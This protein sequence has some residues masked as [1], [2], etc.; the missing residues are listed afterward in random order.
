M[1]EKN[2]LRREAKIKRD[3]LNP[4]EKKLLDSAIC[5]KVLALAAK[6]K[7]KPV[8][9]Y[10]AKGSETDLSEAIVKMLSDGFTVAVPRVYGKKEMKFQ[11]IVSFDDLEDGVFGL[12]EP[13]KSCPVVLP[14]GSIVFVPG[15]AFG[16]DGER[17]GYGAGYY[18]R[19]FSEHKGNL[20]IG[21]CYDFQILEKIGT[22]PSDVPMYSVLTEKRDAEI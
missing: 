21:T 7:D 10:I 6:F 5:G 9:V 15:L 2:I 20:L 14:F 13:K 1:P 8:L 22:E 19:Y 4:S 12:K 3:S 18:D 16:P 17:I 11:Q